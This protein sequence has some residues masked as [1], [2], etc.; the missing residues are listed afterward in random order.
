MLLLWQA[1]DF[2][3]YFVK[4]ASTNFM[5]LFLYIVKATEKYVCKN[6]F[7]QGDYHFRRSGLVGYSAGHK[8]E[9]FYCGRQK[10]IGKF[11]S[12]KV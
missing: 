12:L 3:R 11:Q 2:V 10:Q 6:N 7:L 4:K 1:V 8:L 9:S 5:G